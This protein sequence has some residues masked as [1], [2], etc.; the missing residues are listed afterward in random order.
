MFSVE[1]DITSAFEFYRRGTAGILNP[2]ELKVSV[3]GYHSNYDKYVK[4]NGDSFELAE[5]QITGAYGGPARP[6]MYGLKEKVDY[7]RGNYAKEIFNENIWYDRHK[8]GWFVEW[9]SI[10]YQLE[11]VCIEELMPEV[12]DEMPPVSAKTQRKKNQ[13]GYGGKTLYASGQLAS[14]IVVLV[15]EY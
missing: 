12:S 3:D 5:I 9:D 7:N 4:F 6:F 10:A 1:Q 15:E 14:C 8:R 13:F 11:N 2:A